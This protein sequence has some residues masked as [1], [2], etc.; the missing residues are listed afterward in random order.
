MRVSS[1]TCSF[2]TPAANPTRE[3]ATAKSGYHPSL[4]NTLRAPQLTATPM[5]AEGLLHLGGAAKRTRGNCIFISPHDSRGVALYE[6]PRCAMG[7]KA[8]GRFCSVRFDLRLFTCESCQPLHRLRLNCGNEVR[9]SRHVTTNDAF[10]KLLPDL[11]K[12]HSEGPNR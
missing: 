10:V 9:V 11:I 7:G 3:S 5:D 1:Y 4:L 2:F 6:W 12:L 8:I